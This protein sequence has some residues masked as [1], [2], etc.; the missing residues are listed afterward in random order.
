M[1]LIYGFGKFVSYKGC[2]YVFPVV[3]FWDL[4][5]SFAF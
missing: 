5:T 2:P 1:I 4:E 3:R